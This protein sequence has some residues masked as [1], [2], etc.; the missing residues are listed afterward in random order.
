MDFN[1]IPE[2]D[3][4]LYQAIVQGMQELAASLP[5]QLRPF[6]APMLQ[7]ATE[8]VASVSPRD[9]R[10]FLVQAHDFLGQFLAHEGELPLI[11]EGQ[12]TAA[13]VPPG[14]AQDAAAA[15][16][17]PAPTVPTWW[18]PTAQ[19]FTGRQPTAEDVTAIL[20]AIEAKPEADEL[21]RLLQSGQIAMEALAGE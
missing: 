12:L 2:A 10:G 6:A 20:D 19:E 9:L 4:P 14:E 3:R 5:P 11:V 1:L 15:L 17:A 7:M 13:L 21:A 8:R 16:P 18:D